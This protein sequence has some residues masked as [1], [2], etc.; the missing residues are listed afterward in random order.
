MH[1]SSIL[2][3]GSG[4][5]SSAIR[6]VFS[7]DCEVNVCT[8]KDFDAQNPVSVLA[9]IEKYK[10]D[11]IFNTVVYG[12]IDL[13]ALNPVDAYSVNTLFPLFLTR[14]SALR[15]IILIHFST[16]AVF[17]DG[18]LHSRKI[19]VDACHPKNIYGVTKFAA[20]SLLLHSASQ[21]YIFR[22][23]L[24]LGYASEKKQFFERMLAVGLQKKKLQIANDV[25]STPVYSIDV[26]KKIKQLLTAGASTGLYH[27]ASPEACSLQ[28]LM[29]YAVVV[30]HVDIQIEGVSSAS[31]PT[32]DCKNLS[33]LIASEKI[34]ALPLWKRSVTDYCNRYAE[35]LLT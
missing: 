24:L 1:F 29:E 25:F 15:N 31:F 21:C 19:E 9:S 11:I 13:C 27:L 22:L 33:P 18:N 2:I 12:G 8:R 16:E 30:L 26:A 5:M 17:D 14:Q 35:F 6:S 7:D 10:P 32:V 4:K 34:E 23:P 3:L 28:Q 20:D